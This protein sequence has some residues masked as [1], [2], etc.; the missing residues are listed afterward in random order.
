MAIESYATLRVHSKLYSLIRNLSTYAFFH[1]E[2]YHVAFPL[3]K[4][5]NFYCNFHSVC[6]LASAP[7]YLSSDV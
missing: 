1:T 5:L 2:I 7:A 3:E 4:I 6:L